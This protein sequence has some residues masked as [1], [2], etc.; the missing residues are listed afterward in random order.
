LGTIQRAFQK[1][2]SEGLV[3]THAG[4]G[5]KVISPIPFQPEDT[6]RKA[7]LIHQAEAFLLE[8]LS[9][10]YA[11]NEV[12]DA[13]R[14]ALARWRM[15]SQPPEA[16]AHKI[17]HFSGSHDLAVVWLA[18]HFGDFSPGYR[19]QLDFC[20]S[21][22][23]LIS[24]AEGKSDIVGTHLWDEVSETYNMPF[25]RN[26]FPGEKM[27]M[28]TLAYRRIGWL[29]KLGNPKDFQNINDLT[30]QDIRYINRH[31]GSGTRVYLDSLLKKKGIDSSSIRGYLNQKNTHSE[32]AIE[33]AEDRADVGLG[34][35]A[36]ARAHHLDFIFLN[37]ERY[38]LVVKPKLFDQDPIR[39]MISWL[40]GDEF[41]LLLNHL[42]GY[43]HS[44][45]GEVHW[46]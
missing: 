46:V 34:I 27:A 44:E 28:I 24:L 19:L 26:L 29:V 4:K 16:T 39:N 30:R 35:E 23:G 1:L 5:T 37:R 25:V 38:D 2:V 22:T 40:K 43:D 17:L 32:I 12:E 20:G 21:L 8:V 13:F 10:G 33:I 14:I 45:S 11:Q 3:S 7:N 15:V 18:A 41:R 6:L 9:S 36:A 31:M 42:G